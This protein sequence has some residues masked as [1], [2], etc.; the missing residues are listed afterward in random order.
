MADGWSFLY[1]VL[2]AIFGA[3]FPFPSR[4]MKLLWKCCGKIGSL[5]I[6]HWLSEVIE[7]WR[8]VGK[9]AVNR[10]ASLDT[11][12]AWSTQRLF[13]LFDYWGCLIQHPCRWF[14]MPSRFPLSIPIYETFRTAAE[15]PVVITHEAVHFGKQRRVYRCKGTKLNWNRKE[16]ANFYWFDHGFNWFNGWKGGMSRWNGCAHGKNF[17]SHRWHGWH[18]FWLALKRE[19]GEGTQKARKSRKGES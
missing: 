17:W 16:I 1:N 10:Y 11:S 2:N 19:R 14:V 3:L 13:G 18:R 4:Q 12:F 9:S 7:K 5:F 6:T 15:S 8:S